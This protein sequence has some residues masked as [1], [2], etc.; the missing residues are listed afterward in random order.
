M[1]LPIF[2]G[3]VDT[4]FDEMFKLPRT[5]EED[6]LRRLEQLS[7]V[8]THDVECRQVHYSRKRKRFLGLIRLT[9]ARKPQ[10]EDEVEDGVEDGLEEEKSVPTALREDSQGQLENLHAEDE[11]PSKME[12]CKIGSFAIVHSLFV[13][14]HGISIIKVFP[15][16]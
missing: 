3:K 11:W 5:A 9:K 10:Q 1:D 2:R 13:S 8:P 15:Y 14:S 12:D 4:T 7:K 6:R 16:L